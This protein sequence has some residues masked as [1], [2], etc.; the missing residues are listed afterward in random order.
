MREKIRLDTMSDINGFVAAVSKVDS[1]VTL[2]DDEGHRVSATS[3][4]GAIYSME[5]ECIYCHCEKDIYGTIL[6]WIA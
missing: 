5:W 2:E 4:L 1:K 6:P 3:L